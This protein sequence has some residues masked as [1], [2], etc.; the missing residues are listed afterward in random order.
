MGDGAV[1]SCINRA[2]TFHVIVF[3]ALCPGESSYDGQPGGM[4]A[5]LLNIH[6]FRLRLHH[7]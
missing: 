2:L 3:A 6:Q 5:R 1:R 7:R 4:D